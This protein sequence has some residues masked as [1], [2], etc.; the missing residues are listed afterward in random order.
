M[1]IKSPDETVLKVLCPVSSRSVDAGLSV[2][3]VVLGSRR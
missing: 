1:I 2:F 3:S